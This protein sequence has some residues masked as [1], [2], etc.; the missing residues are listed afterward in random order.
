VSIG[1]IKYG[2]R[3]VKVCWPGYFTGDFGGNTI[4]LPPY[5]IT[6]ARCGMDGGLVVSQSCTNFSS[7]LPGI[8]NIQLGTNFYFRKEQL[9][10]IGG[11]GVDIAIQDTSMS[12]TIKSRHD[13]TSN[14]DAI[15]YREW[16]ITKQADVAAKTYRSAV[17]PYVG[18][19]NITDELI[20]FLSS[21]INIAS[22]VLIKKTVVKSTQLDSV[23][24]DDLVVDKINITVTITVFVAGNYFDITLNVK[25]K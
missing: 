5:Y 17:A 23:A 24:Q 13:L 10:E 8:S 1:A 9:D 19:Y 16:S 6:A 14:M 15:E 20:A 11:G 12:Q 18:K 2:N 7:S 4:T 25:S 3:R 22:S 21:V